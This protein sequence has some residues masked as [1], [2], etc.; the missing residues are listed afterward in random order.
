MIS[1]AGG[2]VGAGSTCT[3]QVNVT[4]ITSGMHVNT[5]GDLT[6]SSG[7]S[8][9]ATDTLTVNPAADP[10]VTKTDG[11]TSATPGGSVTYTIVVSNAGP[12]PDPAVTLADTFPAPPLTCTYTSVAAGGATGNTAAGSGDLAETLSL[13]AG[14]SVTY[15]VSCNID[16]DAT[17]ALSN[18][19]SITP[20]ITDLAPGNNSATDNDTVLAPEADLAV[21][22]SDGVTTAVPGQ[23]TLTYT[24]VASNIGPSDDPS[25]SLTD[26]F[27]ADLTCTYTSVA[28]G[29]ATGN[30]AAGSGIW[31][32]R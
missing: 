32:K 9:T 18:T 16:A 24:I 13:P 3:V 22:K 27:L 11:V 19:A 30:T 17:G 5:T 6:S 31:R 25:V 23:T 8:G 7:N 15:T 28:A 26:T 14:S 4:S 21:T 29:G 1:L 12:S 2:S 10:S 20:S